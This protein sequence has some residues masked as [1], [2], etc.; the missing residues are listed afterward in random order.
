MY[1]WCPGRVLEEGVGSPGNEVTDCC[2]LNPGLLQEQPALLTSVL[3]LQLQFFDP[4][5]L[6]H[7]LHSM[8]NNTVQFIYSKFAELYIH[9]SQSFLFV[10]LIHSS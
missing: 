3:S 2:E 6:K 10:H 5:F 8:K 9:H 1:V 7:N 4:S